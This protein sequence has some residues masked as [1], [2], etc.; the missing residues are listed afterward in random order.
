MI[1]RSLSGI[2]GSDASRHADL[3]GE[4]RAVGLAKVC[5]WY[6]GFSATTTQSTSMPG[7]LTCRG[8]SEPRSAMRSTCAMTSRRFVRRHRDG[9][10]LQRQ[11]LA[12]HRELPSGRRWCRG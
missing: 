3:A 12:L 8:L 7:I 4:G 5:M 10:R 6:S 9:Q 1:L 2:G 11:R